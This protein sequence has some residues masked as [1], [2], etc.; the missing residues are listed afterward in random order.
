M[1]K[2]WID[3]SDLTKSLSDH[4]DPIVVLSGI[5]LDFLYCAF[6]VIL[7]RYALHIITFNNVTEIYR[8]SVHIRISATSAGVPTNDPT[9]PAIKAIAAF[10]EKVVVVPS[11]QT[12]LDHKQF[13]NLIIELI[14]KFKN[15]LRKVR[16]K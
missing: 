4:S 13:G 14:T 3:K 9:A 7:L 16:L 15:E 2:K 11:L 12:I 5:Y 8:P 6:N 1:N 10:V